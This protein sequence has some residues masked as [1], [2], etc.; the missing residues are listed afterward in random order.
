MTADVPK[1]QI[2]AW[3]PKPVARV[4]REIYATPQIAY[5][6]SREP[7]GELT[8]DEIIDVRKSLI[9]LVGDQRMRGVWHE[10]SRRRRGTFLHPAVRWINAASA[11]ER[12]GT[13]MAHLFDRAVQCTTMPA[14]VVWTR[15]QV[16][17]TRSHNLAMARQLR[18][19]ASTTR[20]RKSDELTA[21]AEAYE[22][23]ARYNDAAMEQA[24]DRDRG[25][26]GDRA[27]AL[28]I[29]G[30]CRY[31]FYRPMYGISAIISSVALGH[32]IKPRSVRQ[33]CM[34][35]P[36]LLGMLALPCG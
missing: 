11:E 30:R 31:L 27:C 15:S 21:A 19:D 14:G 10:L 5:K 6:A 34:D 4:A 1:L 29:A 26:L 36:Y 24:L 35:S 16:E 3:V 32:E 22:Q 28:A 2:P 23:F 20:S 18:I 12:Q 17:Q 7:I 25:N 13:A 9:S 33:W 8:V